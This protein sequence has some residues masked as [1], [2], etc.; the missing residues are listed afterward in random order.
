MKGRREA[1]FF[2]GSFCVVIM[3]L[4]QRLRQA[5][6]ASSK[7]FLLSCVIAMA[8]AGL[9][10]GVWYPAPYAELAGGHG[11][12]W[13]VMAVDIVCGPL[14]TFV[15][16]S[17]AKPRAELVRDIGLVVLVQIGALFYGL[18]SVAQARPVW[19]AFE[20]N[21][22]RV[23]SIP[24]LANQS[25]DAAP[26]SLRTLSW[27]GP[28]LLGVRLVQPTDPDFV[29]SVKSSLEGNH[30]AFRP[31]RWQAYDGQAVRQSLLPMARLIARHSS[32]GEYIRE[33]VG[34]RDLGQL[35]YLPLVAN[36]VTDWVVVADRSTGQ[37]VAY[38]HL[39]G[40]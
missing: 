36:N 10:F 30:P 37:P 13:L 38:L 31:A 20:G 21:R 5:L 8:V 18:Y 33:V 35:G 15:I 32:E 28:K 2:V 6:W 1:P 23:V 26:E 29:Q 25:L 22:F 24:D 14:L 39:D 17:P 40:F 34:K 19:L 27:T 3:S 12:F 4:S 7:H 9:V 16:F 11:L